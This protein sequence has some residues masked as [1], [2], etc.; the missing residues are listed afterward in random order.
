M[1]IEHD[2]QIDT[3]ADHGSGLEQTPS[4]PQQG[5]ERP[6][7]WTPPPGNPGSDQDALEDRNNGT[8]K[9]DAD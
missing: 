3:G 5:H 8:A 2:A 4:E 7:N 6:A 1:T 9:P